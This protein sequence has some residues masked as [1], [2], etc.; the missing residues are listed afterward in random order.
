MFGKIVLFI[1]KII[2]KTSIHS[3]GKCRIC[4]VNAGG[5]MY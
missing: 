4:N 2:Q 1:V 5:T 3:V